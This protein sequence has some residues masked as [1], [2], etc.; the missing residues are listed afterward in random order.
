MNWQIRIGSQILICVVNRKKSLITHRPFPKPA[1]PGLAGW[2]CCSRRMQQFGT[3]V[4]KGDSASRSSRNSTVINIVSNGWARDT[5]QDVE[6]YRWYVVATIKVIDLGEWGMRKVC[7]NKIRPQIQDIVWIN[8]RI[9]QQEATKPEYKTAIQV[10]D[11]SS[12]ATERDSER[13]NQQRSSRVLAKS[14]SEFQN[15]FKSSLNIFSFDLAE[16]PAASFSSSLLFLSRAVKMRSMSPGRV[17]ISDL[18]RCT[19][20][21]GGKICQL[22][23]GNL[24]EKVRIRGELPLSSRPS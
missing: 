14:D 9:R 2:V 22:M 15:L 19:V 11:L 1:T 5:T 10:Q 13:D 17:S 4:I 6:W 23:S 16:A 7:T 20:F 24:R 12:R 3:F 8:S 18:A 21:C